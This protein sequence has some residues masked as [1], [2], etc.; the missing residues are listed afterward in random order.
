MLDPPPIT[1]PTGAT[2]LRPFRCGCGT[3]EQHQSV[4]VPKLLGHSRGSEIFAWLI[5]VP[6]PSISSTDDPS[7]DSRFATT[8][9][10]APA[11]TTT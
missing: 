2:M 4:S 8:Q 6:P 3:V 11:P 1:F 9:P 5:S 7:S 10:A